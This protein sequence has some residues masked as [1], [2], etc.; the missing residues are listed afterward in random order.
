MSKT[1]FEIRLDLLSMAQS[2]LTEQCM[3]ERIRLENDWNSQREIAM[4]QIHDQKEASIP[5][6]P[7]VKYFSV[8]EVI[9]MAKKLNDFVSNSPNKE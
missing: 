3:N 9:E 2:I 7:T 6:F 4:V 5:N 8:D 1:P